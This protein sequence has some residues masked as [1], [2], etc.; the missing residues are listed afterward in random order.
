MG[1]DLSLRAVHR[2]VHTKSPVY[3]VVKNPEH[4]IARIEEHA[5]LA[6]PLRGDLL[7]ISVQLILRHV[8]GDVVVSRAAGQVI[9]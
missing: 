5:V 8:P 6:V 2:S 7:E 1:N 9:I 3:C 4:L